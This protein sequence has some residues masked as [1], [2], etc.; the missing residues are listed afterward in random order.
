MASHITFTSLSKTDS[1]NQAITFFQG[2]TFTFA[3]QLA[4]SNGSPIDI[5]GYTLTGQFRSDFNASA[6]LLSFQASD[7]TITA[8]IPNKLFNV[9]V[10]GGTT[11][12]LRFTADSPDQLNGVYD[13]ELDAPDGSSDK[14]LYGTFTILREV[15]RE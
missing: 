11:A 9:N 5:T 14:A 1:R 7:G 10:N 12:A 4:D 3:I 2:S 8:D 6:P 13:F 15:T